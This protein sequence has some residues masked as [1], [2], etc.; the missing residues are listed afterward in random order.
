MA[1]SNLAI[2]LT[3]Q[4]NDSSEFRLPRDINWERRYCLAHARGR[5]QQGAHDVAEDLRRRN[6]P[7]TPANLEVELMLGVVRSRSINSLIVANPVEY[8]V[9]ERIGIAVRDYFALAEVGGGGD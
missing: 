3:T 5:W 6:I 2:R 4:E 8:S 7:I 1:A 9:E